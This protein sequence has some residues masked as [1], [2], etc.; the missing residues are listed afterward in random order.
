MGAGY[1]NI[2]ACAV[3]VDYIAQAQ[4]EALAVQLV[5]ANIQADGRTDSENVED[6]LCLVYFDPYT[7]DGK[8]HVRN[9]CLTVRRPARSNAEGLYECFTC[10]LT[11]ADIPDWENKLVGFESDGA[12]V[13]IGLVV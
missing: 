6:K 7:Q 13:N 3:F 12:S 5:K 8:V 11:Y 1:K 10:A 9:K 2:Q 4:R